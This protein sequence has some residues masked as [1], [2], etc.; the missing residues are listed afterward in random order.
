[1]TDS[2]QNKE[3]HLFPIFFVI[4]SARWMILRNFILT[5]I[6]AI[7]FSFLLP[8]KYTAVTTLMPPS[9]QPK[10]PMSSI[11]ADV[12]VPGFVFP[13][14]TSSSEI[15]VEML[16]SRSVGERVLRRQ[17]RQREDSLCLYKIL[18]YPSV[19]TA[20]DEMK[21]V[22][23]FMLNEQGIIS[24]IVEFSAP[25][26]AAA[27]ANAY[28]EELDLVNQEKSVS[29][30]KNSRIYIE[31][32]LLETQ[33]K[34]KNATE[35]LALFQ[36]EN[37]AVS[38]ENQMQASIQQLGEIQGQITTKEV[39]LGVM[40]QSMRSENPLVV[41]KR[42]EIKELRRQFDEFQFG[43]NNVAQ[44][45]S[46]FYL[47]FIDVPEVS[48]Q[49]ADLIREVKAQETIWQLLNQQYYQAKIE[50]ARNT[51]TIQILDVAIPPI[52]PSSPNRKVLVFVI[53]LLSI[54]FSILWAFLND[55]LKAVDKNP[56]D[57]EKMEIIKAEL[58]KD[59]NFLRKR[60]S[61]RE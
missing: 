22:A 27:V 10:T 26:L 30:A 37:K 33:E 56:S 44:Q 16:K 25:E 35:K 40:L 49:L 14:N 39:E 17:F 31:S 24:V 4:L 38:L 28:V 61:T 45:D 59:L 47:P 3:I 43:S 29:R 11:L 53:G 57:K 6:F 54:L 46:G 12:S 58:D 41:R 15:L 34:L 2:R 42:K 9:E 52:H 7:L 20:F 1:M 13:T 60:K 8:R 19:E 32:Q 51:P 48:F 5:V 21:K 50:E 55:Y 36:Q 23:H 18:K